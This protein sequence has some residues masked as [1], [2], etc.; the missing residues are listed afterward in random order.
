MKKAAIY[1]E[2]DPHLLDHIAPLCELLN[3]PLY[4][5]EEQDY[6]LAKQYYPQI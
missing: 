5:S 2:H 1:F 3:M 4:I 6:V